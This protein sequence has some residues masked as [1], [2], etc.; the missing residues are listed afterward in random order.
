MPL[1]QCFTITTER[2][3]LRALTPEVHQQLFENSS[4]AE[5]M[6]FLGIGPEELGAERLRHTLG[7]N[8]WRTSYV[9]FQL[10][11]KLS[12]QIIGGCGFHTWYT[13]HSRAEIG[14]AMND[15]AHKNKGYMKEAILPIIRYGFD[16]MNLNRIEAFISPDNIPSQK[17]VRAMGFTR[18]GLLREH[19]CKN[20]QIQD[21]AVYG[22]LRTEY[23]QP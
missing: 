21:S 2:L 23:I 5:I 8:T 1:P 18:E 14:Y 15:D 13:Q 4:D 3:V 22:L 12:G 19:Y 9:N 17:L 20:G 11:E 10:L 6:G 16:T 7:R